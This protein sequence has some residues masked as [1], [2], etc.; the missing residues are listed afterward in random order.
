MAHVLRLKSKSS[1]AGKARFPILY[2]TGRTGKFD[3]A[4]MNKIQSLSTSPRFFPRRDVKG[5]K[6]HATTR[7]GHRNAGKTAGASYQ[8][9]E[10][11]GAA[12]PEIGAENRGRA[13]LEKMGW[14]K[15][16]ALGA[17]DNKGILQPVIHTVKI[18]RAGL[19]VLSVIEAAET[20][21][22]SVGI[23]CLTPFKDATNPSK[24]P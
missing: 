23:V 4:M 11:V 12:A 5:Q 9:G 22:S 24:P 20:R 17:L 10:V 14:S 6:K 13:M 2:K 8:D 15:G 21:N 1:G 3:E 16:T 7:H 19:G 18:S